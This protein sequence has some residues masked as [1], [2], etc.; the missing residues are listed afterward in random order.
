MNVKV[1]E[2]VDER[3]K[4]GVLRKEGGRIAEENEK[5]NRK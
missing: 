1:E 4:E 2:K 5:T 3:E